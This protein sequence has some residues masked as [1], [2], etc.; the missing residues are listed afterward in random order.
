V[1]SVLGRRVVLLSRGG[2]GGGEVWGSKTSGNISKE[3]YGTH[4]S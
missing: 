1:C 4:F 2:G 3:A